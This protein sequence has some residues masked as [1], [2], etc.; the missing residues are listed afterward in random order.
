MMDSVVTPATKHEAVYYDGE[1]VFQRVRDYTKDKA[2]DA[3]AASAEKVYRDDYVLKTGERVLG[4]WVFTRGLLRDWLESGDKESQRA[5][6]ILTNK[7]AFGPLS[8]SPYLEDFTRSR[9]AAYLLEAE[10]DAEKAKLGYND[11][12]RRDLANAAFGHI[13]QWASGKVFVKT[14]MVALTVQSL[15]KNNDAHP[16]P[17]TLPAIKKAGDIIWSQWV[18]TDKAFKYVSTVTPDGEQPT[19][20][21]D[22]NLLISPV[23]GWLY[24]ETK[25]KRYLDKAVQS[26]DSGVNEAWLGSGK[27]YNQNYRWSFDEVEWI[28][29]VAVVTPTAAPTRTRPP[30][31]TPKPPCRACPAWCESQK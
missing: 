2:W 19:S 30:T 9:E 15:I 25:D 23:F 20:Q 6:D 3:C 8:V 12:R 10:L 16:D 29:S 22:L 17:R 1:N 5:I 24:K 28:K 13:D 27:Q 7:S 21:V 31:P 26:F 4:Y 11:V 14:F 18:P